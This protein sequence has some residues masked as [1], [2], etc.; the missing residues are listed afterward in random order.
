MPVPLG[1]TGSSILRFFAAL[2]MTD[3]WVL[4]L[5]NYRDRLVMLR[6]MPSRTSQWARQL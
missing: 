4:A 2:R 1:V 6:S 5:H 3:V